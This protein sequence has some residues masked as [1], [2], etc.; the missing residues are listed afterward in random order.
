MDAKQNINKKDFDSI[1]RL[2]LKKDRKLKPI[3]STNIE[4]DR[5]SL[6]DVISICTGINVSSTTCF[7]FFLIYVELYQINL[8]DG[9]PLNLCGK[10]LKKLMDF[11]SFRIQCRASEDL[12]RILIFKGDEANDYDCLNND[13][14]QVKCTLFSNHK[15]LLSCNLT[16]NAFRTLKKRM[17]WNLI[18]QL[19]V[20]K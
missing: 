7:Y 1:C 2:C 12:L 13:D 3:L 15:I 18:C 10:C 4:E 19:M 9:L 20:R 17:I 14:W 8:E 11:H 5:Q 6:L 16:K